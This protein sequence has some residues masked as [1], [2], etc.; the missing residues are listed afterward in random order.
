MTI[1][2][3]DGEEALPGGAGAG[4][5]VE[6]A[7]V[8]DAAR[9]AHA[10]LVEQVRAH[11]F[12]YYVRNAP[13]VS[14]AEYDE[15]M[16][17]LAR[18]EAEHPGLQTPDSPTQTVGGT[19]ST[20]FT[21]V[22]HLEPML[23][24]DNAFNL[25]E[26]AGWDERVRRDAGAGYHYLCELKVDGLA[27][28]L[29]YTDGR[30][31][32]AAT[33]GDGR[34][35]EDVTLNVAS[36]RGVPARLSGPD[37]PALVEV[38]GEVFFPVEA[39]ADLNA[40]LL[41]AGR[42]PF[43]NP[44]NAA[45]G[46]LRQK[47]PKVTASRPLALVVHG[48]GRVQGLPDGVEITR[49]SHAYDLA[50]SW[51]LPVSDRYRVVE[52]L[53]GVADFIAY[54][55]EHR[56]D[57]S[58]EIDG[59]VVKV[60]EV[61]VQRR[62]GATSRAPR[63]AIAYK[64]PPEEV[65]TRLLDI[66]VNVGRTGRVTPYAVMTPVRVSGSTVA[67]ATLHNAEEVARKGVLI[68]DVVVLRKAGDVIPEILAPVTDRRDGTQRAFVMP[69]TCPECSSPLGPEK[70]GDVDIRCPNTRRCPAQLRERLFHLAGRG[71]LDIEMLGYEAA[72]ALLAAG[73]LG[74]EGDIFDLDEAALRRVAL[75]TRKDGS[76]TANGTRLLENLAAA[77]DRP[78]WR[79]LVA[80]SIRHVG[81]TAA[82]ALA[83]ALGSMAAI[84]AASPEQLA[85]VDGVGPVI[86]EAVREWFALD[87]HREIVRKWQ[88]A[89]VRMAE[90]QDTST[91]RTLE[92]LTLVLTGTLEGFSRDE[93]T[94]AITARGGKATGSVSR[95]T[96]VLIAGDSP[97]SKLD[98]AL[99][100]GV[101][102]L[103]EAG[104]HRLLEQGRGALSGAGPAG[105]SEGGADR[106]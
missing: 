76:L 45:S 66:K 32:R 11:Q 85:A 22:D 61:A 31:T 97:G 16:A 27:V 4:S 65:T 69:T 25:D 88:R 36:I 68:G 96:D 2:A 89:G 64:Y 24:L 44:R 9:H 70:P 43:A 82:Q 42:P 53:G 63:W 7:E 10:D 35:G 8:P 60:D 30:L 101:P 37:V 86:A 5:L 90:R 47:D 50:R 26:L 98:K 58:H 1:Q 75:F 77:R 103:D 39:F 80:L 100:L 83:R 20:E 21:P 91:P 79:V 54:Y 99:A 15:L 94:E 72:L 67:M 51:G 71:A 18:L 13:L 17:R 28:N 57:V 46:S 81:P 93:A 29:L 87:W 14:D 23:S 62:L 34:T 102:V 12:A 78:L 3:P 74:D 49:Q 59:V 52:E 92:G 19:F 38:R 106:Q 6:V 105:A 84:E 33:R 55:G 41:A 104:F 40:T 48:L 56:H 73:V 95:R